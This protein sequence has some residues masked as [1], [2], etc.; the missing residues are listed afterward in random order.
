M[1]MNRP[2]AVIFV[3]LFALVAMGSAQSN[4]TGVYIGANVGGASGTSDL[5]TSPVFSPTGY[6]A[7]TSP[8]AIAIAGAQ[9][10]NPSSF[11]GGVQVGFNYQISHFVL[12]GETDFGS[13]QLNQF[14]TKSGL[15]P[16][17]APTGFTVAQSVR[18]NWLFTA[19]PRFGVA[20]GRVMVYGTVGLAETHINY[21][22]LFTDTFATARES[23]GVNRNRS[24]WI[25]GGGAEFRLAHH[26]SVKAEYLHAD[27]GGVTAT[28]TN[29][30]AFT[31]PIPFPTNV[32]THHA[33][34]TTNIGRAG[35]N[36]RF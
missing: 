34:L 30:T 32:W 14:V 1:K 31:P 29:L 28:S 2:L 36:F 13:M 22:E 27:F 16:C 15:Y 10:L 11:S 26:W 20:F 18:T 5:K 21:K 7:T 9:Q 23:G 3:L 8:G 35:I 19:R 4:F 17:C 24:G 6:F 25:G 33:N 12:G